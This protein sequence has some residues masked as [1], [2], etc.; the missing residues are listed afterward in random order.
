[1]E[2]L[3][4]LIALLKD[5]RV[6]FLIDDNSI[7]NLNINSFTS[8]ISCIEIFLLNLLVYGIFDIG[9]LLRLFV[10]ICLIDHE[11]ECLAGVR[12]FAEVFF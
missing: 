6:C 2:V 3:Q 1:M 11:G 5:F 8:F 12:A 10:I 7:N 4:D 9:L